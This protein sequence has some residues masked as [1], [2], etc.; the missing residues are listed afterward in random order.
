PIEL[1]NKRLVLNITGRV[2]DV[3]G[4]PLIGVNILVKGTNKGTTTDI[5]GRFSINDVDDQAVLVLSYIGYQSQEVA[6]GGKTNLTIIMQEDVQTLDEVVVVGY[7]TQMKENLTGAVSSV[8]A[9]DI[10]N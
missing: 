2:T 5:D 1:Y 6:V 7:G 3:A 4:E 9:K 8:A 10:S